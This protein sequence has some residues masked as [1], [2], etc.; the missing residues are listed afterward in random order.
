MPAYDDSR[1]APPAPVASV[2]LT[3]PD[4]GGSIADVPMLILRGA[5]GEPTWSGVVVGPS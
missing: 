3:H 2:S 5:D 4:H 1:F